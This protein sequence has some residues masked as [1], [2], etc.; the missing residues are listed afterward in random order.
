MPT[1]K[2]LIRFH[3]RPLR[4]YKTRVKN[5]N[6]CPQK[7]GI[8]FKLTIMTPK[9]PNSAKR[10]V[11]KIKLS[12]KKFVFGYIPGEGNNLQRFSQVLIRGGL[13]R[14]LPG[15][16]YTII[17]GKL[18]LHGVYYRRQG[19][20]KYGT[21]IWWK[22]KKRDRSSAN[23]TL[24]KKNLE[25]IQKKIYQKKLRRYRKNFFNWIVFNLL[26]V[27]EKKNNKYL[28][29]PQSF[30]KTPVF[31][32]IKDKNKKKLLMKKYLKKRNKSIRK[33]L[34]KARR[35]LLRTDYLL[36]LKLGQASKFTNKKIKFQ[37]RTYS[38]QIMIQKSY[39]STKFIKFF[40]CYRSLFIWRLPVISKLKL[41][42]VYFLLQNKIFLYKNLIKNNY[43]KKKN[44]FFFQ[45][46][47]YQRLFKKEYLTNS[48]FIDKIL[49]VL[50]IQGKKIML[51]KIIIQLSQFLQKQF[52]ISLFFF[53]TLILKEITIMFELVPM[54]QAGRIIYIPLFLSVLRQ[55]TL[56]LKFFKNNIKLRQEQK[57]LFKL[58]NELLDITLLQKGLTLQKLIKHNELA[59]I[60]QPN[61]HYR[62]KKKHP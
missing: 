6:Q 29:L 18:D 38:K 14:D 36:N 26:L 12:T 60:S 13:I 21:K 56:A 43:L 31:P 45:K 41:F 59:F 55:L 33:Y 61:L 5:L 22:P 34:L 50:L 30:F 54:K 46:K 7:K 37:I 35:H 44:I 53:F 28:V 3:K 16:H 49:R 8:C 1:F 57:F 24:K 47:K 15:V 9:K 19:R 2:Q 52:N 42:V 39:S 27:K 10:K 17:R 23:L 40:L 48:Y 11:A 62:W 32:L 51:E 58:L 4:K 20:S 25:F